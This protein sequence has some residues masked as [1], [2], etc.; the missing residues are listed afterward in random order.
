M[1]HGVIILVTGV[2]TDRYLLKH[3]RLSKQVFHYKTLDWN[4]KYC[5]VQIEKTSYWLTDKQLM[6]IHVLLCQGMR[7]S[8]GFPTTI[9][10]PSILNWV[11]LRAWKQ[12]T[13]YVLCIC[14]QNQMQFRLPWQ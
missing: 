11:N 14:H 12:L 3:P 7:F 1:N 5:S 10:K 6:S 8:V 2:I 4:F 13:D 9:N